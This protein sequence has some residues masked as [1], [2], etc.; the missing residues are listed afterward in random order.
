M[1]TCLKLTCLVYLDW[2]LGTEVPHRDPADGTVLGL[3]IV[4]DVSK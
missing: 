2:A 3:C 4:S 1:I